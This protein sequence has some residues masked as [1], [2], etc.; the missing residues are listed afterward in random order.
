MLPAKTL[1]VF[2][3]TSSVGLRKADDSVMIYPCEVHLSILQSEL[4]SR[5]VSFDAN[6]LVKKIDKLSN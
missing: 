6:T 2:R 5:I 3:Q 4:Y 1:Q